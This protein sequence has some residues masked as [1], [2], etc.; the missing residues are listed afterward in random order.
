MVEYRVGGSLAADDPTYI[1]READRTLYRSLVN[2]ELCY[3]LT[4]RQMGKSSLRLRTRQRLEAEGMGRCAALDLTRIGSQQITPEQWYLGLAFDLQRKF[5]LPNGVDLPTW[6][7]GLGLL[8]P[9]QK[10]SYWIETV[11]LNAQSDQPLFIFLDEIDA[12][13]GLNFS[14]GDFFGLV[15]FCYNQRAENLAY[16]RLN[17]AMFGVATPHDLVAAADQ[18]PFNIGR[19]ISLTGFTQDETTPLAAGLAGL[20]ERPD[21][22]L[23]AVLHWTGG[24]PFLTQKLCNLIQI[25]HRNNPLVA[26]AE[27]ARVEALVRSH[28]LHQWE[29][30]DDPEHLRTIRDR[31]LG[32][33]LRSG[34]LLSLHQRML[35]AGNIP[36]DGSSDQAELKLSGIAIARNSHLQVANPIY[37]EVFNLAWVNQCLAQQRPYAVMLQAWVASNCQDDSRLLM[38]QALQDA[39]QWAAHKSLSDLDYRY[40]SASQEWDAKMVRLELEA[41]TQANRVLA[42]AQRKANQTIWFSYLSLGSCL[43]ISLVALLLSLLRP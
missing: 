19:A 13:K 43:A 42:E 5:R 2:G 20:T 31:L 17:W 3:V 38:G 24:Q 6:W 37:A 1:E 29:A 36:T 23:A 16:R 7:Q 26:G 15:R 25:T 27:G 32:D 39:L 33:E 22:V 30:Q 4:S 9:V 35:T 21:Q 10:L 14:A 11:L 40:L 41:K 12:V 8:P 28:L 34:R 18:T